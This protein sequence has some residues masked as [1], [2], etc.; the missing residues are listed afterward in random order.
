MSVTGIPVNGTSPDTDNNPELSTSTLSG[1]SE[2]NSTV[3]PNTLI[4][5]SVICVPAT[6]NK[7]AGKLLRIP[8]ANAVAISAADN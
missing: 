2:S 1:G 7:S 4:V 6:S 5:S 3:A 8:L